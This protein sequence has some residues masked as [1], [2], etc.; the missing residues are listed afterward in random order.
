[1]SDLDFDVH[2]AK[3]FGADVNLDQSRVY[4]LVELSE[5]LDKSDRS[6]F[7]AS[8]WV[9]EGTARDGTEETD[10]ATQA[11]HHGTVDTMCNLPGTEILSVRRL[12]LSPLEGLDVNDLLG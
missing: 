10:T 5:S 1:M 7:N 6:L 12:H 3:G 11:L 2:D 9:G 8:E 4:G